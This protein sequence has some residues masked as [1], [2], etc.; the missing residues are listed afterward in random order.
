VRP[1][2]DYLRRQ[3]NLQTRKKEED[4]EERERR[5]KEVRHCRRGGKGEEIHYVLDIST[6]TR[7]LIYKQ[8]IFKAEG[9]LPVGIN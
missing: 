9:T 1:I 3:T 5:M 6:V 4:S 8:I 2:Y 7:E